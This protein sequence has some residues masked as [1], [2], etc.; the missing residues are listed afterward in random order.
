MD[1]EPV[2]GEPS[3]VKAE[4]NVS[5]TPYTDVFVRVFPQYLAMG[6]TS[7]EFWK[8]NPSLVEAYREAWEI[9][10]EYK[11]WELWLQG[12]YIYDALLKVAPV[13]RAALGKGRV[14]PGKYP[15]KPYPI[16]EKQAEKRE[17]DTKRAAFDRLLAALNADS[18]AELKRRAEKKKIEEVKDDAGD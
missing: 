4:V 1:G 11:N 5:S 15:E 16:S 7:D 13:M 9:K 2:T 10:R 3:K 18:E 6:M 12:G 14:E 17:E 8:G